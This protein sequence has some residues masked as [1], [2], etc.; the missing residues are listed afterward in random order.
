[1]VIFIMFTVTKLLF[2][3]CML[4]SRN[5]GYERMSGRVRRN[6]GGVEGERRMRVSN[7]GPIKR[8]FIKQFLSKINPGRFPSFFIREF[9]SFVQNTVIWQ[10]IRTNSSGHMFFHPFEVLREN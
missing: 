1:M 7:F 9:H 6:E 3:S 4:L 8:Q 2:Y 5:L 10:A